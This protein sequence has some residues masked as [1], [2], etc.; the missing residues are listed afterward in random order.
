M[1]IEV[2]WNND[3][4][5]YKCTGVVTLD[6]VRVADE[7]TFNDERFPTAKYLL[8]NAIEIESVELSELDIQI[9]IAND[10]QHSLNNESLKLAFATN[11]PDIRQVADFYVAQF[12]KRHFDWEVRAFDSLVEAN[13]WLSG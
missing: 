1:P 4:I 8:I 2:C 3:A 10:F 6:D 9:D 12:R 7:A 13:M 11:R 5:E